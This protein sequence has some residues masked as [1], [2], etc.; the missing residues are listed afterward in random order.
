MP[1]RGL[2]AALALALLAGCAAPQRRPVH[3]P[4]GRAGQP[5]QSSVPP[6]YFYPEQGQPDA[7]QDRDRYECYRWAAQQTGTDPGMTPVRRPLGPQPMPP[8]RD[9]A[10]VVAGAATGAVLGAMVSRPRY[11]GENAV[12]GA[13]IGTLLGAIGQESRAQA[14]EAAQARHQQA[15]DAA[16]VPVD[17]FR[18]AMGACM[19]ARGYRVG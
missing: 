16:R 7:Q 6:L 3:A 9:G 13:I 4:E 1:M 2:S 11:A 18:R 12:I 5:L 17:N 15:Q 19:Q 14:A 8:V 10:D